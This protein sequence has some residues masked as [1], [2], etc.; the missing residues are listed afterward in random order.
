MKKIILLAAVMLAITACNKG[1]PCDYDSNTNQVHCTEKTY[2]TVVVDGNV[3][4]AENLNYYFLPEGNFCYNDKDC[5][6]FGRLYLF[7]QI[8]NPICPT[9][10]RVPT[11]DEFMKAMKGSNV[12]EINANT[13]L[14]IT[15]GGFRYYDGNYADKDVSAS[16]WTSDEF[17][18][19]R[20]YLIRVTDSTVTAEHFNR[21]IA[22]SIRCIL[23][24]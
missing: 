19:S 11:K 6:T 16:F 14:N 8:K 22:A 18:D 1:R 3:W 20:A 24:R 5:P 9:G 7:D 17:D 2:K 4:M 21:N 15:K 10:W 23:D 13:G 12:D